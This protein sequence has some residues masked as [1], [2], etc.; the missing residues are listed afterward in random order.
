MLLLVGTCVGRTSRALLHQVAFL[1]V[2][3]STNTAYGNRWCNS[4]H[5]NHL[6]FHSNHVPPPPFPFGPFGAFCCFREASS[7]VEAALQPRSVEK[8]ADGFAAGRLEVSSHK[9]TVNVCTR[10]QTRNHEH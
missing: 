8:S 10:T 6:A 9:R 7:F 5:F 1:V 2:S 4:Y 3:R